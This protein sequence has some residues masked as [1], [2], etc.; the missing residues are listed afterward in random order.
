MTA[1]DAVRA[2]QR[3]VRLLVALA[4]ALV[5]AG[6]LPWVTD[7]ETT[8]RLLALP[9]LLAGLLVTGAAL[10]VRAAGRRQPSAPPV[11]RG[12]DGCA[13]GVSAGCAVASAAPAEPEPTP[14]ESA[15]HEP[16]T[17]EPAA[18]GPA[19]PRATSGRSSAAG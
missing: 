8:V 5:L 14:R 1:V 11:E 4:G 18:H 2:R 12:C 15:A 7:G 19:E 3:A 9:L 13:C 10:R 6:L 16:A 17:R